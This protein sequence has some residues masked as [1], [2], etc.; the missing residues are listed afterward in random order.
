MK[1][2]KFGHA[3]FIAEQDSTSLVVDPGAFSTDLQV[4]NTVTAVIITHEHF[5]HL[6]KELLQ[7]I[8]T[9]NPEA[10]IIAH[11]S[12][13]AQ[14]GEFTTKSVHAGDTFEVGGFILEFFGGEHAII[15]PD[16]QAPANLGVMIN[17]RL[18][19]PGDS[20]TI[21]EKPVEI[22]ALPVAAPWLKISETIDFLKAIKPNIA[23]PTHD[24]ILSD[25]GKNL[26]DHML[27]NITQDVGT[28]YKR[29]DN[30]P[31]QA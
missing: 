25:A 3:C 31:L 8:I 13:T 2:T 6:N 17:N 22:L 18:Y 27:P 21:P 23:F 29:I 26:I 7:Q 11:S 1:I 20:F 15:S 30:E 24:G 10:V 14:L 16:W 19:Y 12:I 4:P 28:T 9:K 5:D